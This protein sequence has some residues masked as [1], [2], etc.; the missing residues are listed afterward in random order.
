MDELKDYAYPTMMAEHA[1]KEL[2]KAM[3]DR[4]LD[5]AKMHGVEAGMQVMK[6]LKIIYLQKHEG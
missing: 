3:L 4:D 2:H 6:I 5:S 1:L